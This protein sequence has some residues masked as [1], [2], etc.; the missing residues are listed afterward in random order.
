MKEAPP[1]EPWL[2]AE[3]KVA[4]GPVSPALRHYQQQFKVPHALQI[5]RTARAP[6]TVDGV[7]VAPAAEFLAL[8]SDQA[9]GADPADLARRKARS[10]R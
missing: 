1:T 10:A 6:Y 4:D 2:L 3:T 8:M 7:T 5:V 9:A